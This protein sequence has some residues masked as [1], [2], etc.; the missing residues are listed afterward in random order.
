MTD[1]YMDV[2]AEM[3]TGPHSHVQRGIQLAAVGQ[4]DEA[5]QEFQTA[6][7]FYP[8]EL[9]AQAS[10]LVLFGSLHRYQEAAKVFDQAIQNNSSAPELYFEYGRIL[11]NKGSNAEAIQVLK[12]S[13]E[14]SPAYAEASTALGEAYEKSGRAADAETCYRQA[15]H[16]R[17]DYGPADLKLARL[18]E[19]RNRG[20]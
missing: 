1:L 7:R 4:V 11:L 19:G 15:L 14:L 17:P 16:Y 2:V 18:I 20:H 13:L 8:S 3:Q 6:L 10:L 12:K 5:I 9:T